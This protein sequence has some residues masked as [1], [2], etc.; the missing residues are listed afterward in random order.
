MRI[1]SEREN[2]L[3]SGK[4]G[5]LCL[6]FA[7]AL[8]VAAPTHAQLKWPSG[9]QIVQAQGQYALSEL[10]AISA[11]YGGDPSGSVS[12]EAFEN[13]WAPANLGYVSPRQGWPARG[14]TLG[15]SIQPLLANVKAWRMDCQTNDGPCAKR[16]LRWSKARSQEILSS[17]NPGKMLSQV[18]AGLQ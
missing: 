4:H 5:V 3:F 18:V 15:E 8:F 11:I 2:G 9:L 10:Q 16:A 14:P 7:V 13:G 12:R 1:R 6:C 17:P